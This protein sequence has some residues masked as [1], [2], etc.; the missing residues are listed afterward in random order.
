MEACGIA[1]VAELAHI[2]LLCVKVLTD[3]VDNETEA[4]NHE[5]FLINFNTAVASLK[6]AMPKIISH[7]AGRRL[8][9]L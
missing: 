3:L 2:P 6:E 8:C 4:P 5:Q 9:D 1:W 7:M